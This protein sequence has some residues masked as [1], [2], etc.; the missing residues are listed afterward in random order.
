MFLPLFVKKWS[1]Y[2]DE[3]YCSISSC[4]VVLWTELITKKAFWGKTTCRAILNWVLSLNLQL[5]T[6]ILML[7]IAKTRRIVLQS[8]QHY[9]IRTF[10]PRDSKT[11]FE[12]RM[13][14][15]SGVI[16]SPIFF[17]HGSNFGIVSLKGWTFKILKNWFRFIYA[18]SGKSAGRCFL[19]SSFFA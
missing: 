15:F 14:Q 9:V 18:L 1:G 7:C 12:S 3:F 16:E 4:D 5:T 8:P 6:R 13:A 10:W 2:W 17:K 19:K 11:I